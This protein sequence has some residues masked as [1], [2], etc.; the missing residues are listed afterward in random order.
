MRKAQDVE[1]LKPYDKTKIKT[2]LLRHFQQVDSNGQ[3]QEF[4]LNKYTSNG[5]KGFVLEVDLEYPKE[6]RELYNNYPLAPDKIKI[7]RKILPDYLLKI[8]NLYNIPIADST[9]TKAWSMGHY[10]Q[11]SDFD[12]PCK[13]CI[14]VSPPPP[15]QKHHNPL[16]PKPSP[17]NL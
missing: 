3:I 16:I 2:Y 4:H 12:C 11:S 8:A 15:P 7:K 1:Y 10:R 6:L 17:L 13:V 9:A 5:S 14:G